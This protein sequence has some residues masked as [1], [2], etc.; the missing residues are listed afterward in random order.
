MSS[1]ASTSGGSRKKN[2]KELQEEVANL[3]NNIKLFEKGTKI[4]SGISF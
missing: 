3:Y 1:S 4:F 2:V